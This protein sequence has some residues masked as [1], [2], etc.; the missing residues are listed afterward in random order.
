MPGAVLARRAV[1]EDALRRYAM[2]RR[3]WWA[4]YA[5]ALLVVIAVV[6]AGAAWIWTNGEAA[7]APL[8]TAERAAPEL[9]RLEV[10]S[11]LQLAWR[12]GDATAIGE[13]FS[14]GTVVTYSAHTV[15]GRNATTGQAMWTYTRTNATVCQVAQEQNKTLALYERDGNCDEI[16]AFDTA[17]GKRAW[18]RTLDESMTPIDGHP[19]VIAAPDTLFVWTGAAI[20]A[21][22]I[23]AAPCKP[24]YGSAC[25]ADYWNYDAPQGCT[26][27]HI[28]PGQAGV[29]IGEQCKTGDQLVLRDRYQSQ[30]NDN[31]RL[32][33]SVKSSAVPVT[34]DYFVAAIEPGSSQLTTFNRQN[35]QVLS[36]TQLTPT[37]DV[38]GGVDTALLSNDVVFRA[39]STVYALIGNGS[40]LRW[41]ANMPTLPSPEP[42]NAKILYQPSASGVTALNASDGTTSKTYPGPSTA[43]ASALVPVGSGFLAAGA[44]TEMLR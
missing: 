3:R 43:G 17:T 33:W 20:Y 36:E 13:P 9:P 4:W 32:L 29:L 16:S 26:F 39:R 7:N 34:A 19:D 22:G 24:E 14:V 42:Q 44:S 35:G 25:G 31:N 18:Q 5:T 10:S 38:S 2:R 12:S 23:S 11:P 27:D 15:T 21:V 37:P 6:A 1:A 8:H 28:A 30:D 41:S 40:R